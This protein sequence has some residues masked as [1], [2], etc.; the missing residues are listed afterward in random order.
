MSSASGKHID[1]SSSAKRV[2]TLQLP[3]LCIRGGYFYCDNEALYLRS[4]RNKCSL[5]QGF[6]QA[7]DNCLSLTEIIKTIYGVMDNPSVRMRESLH[8]NVH[9]ILSDLRALL[10]DRY[11]HLKHVEWLPYSRSDNA[12]YLYRFSAEYVLDQMF[13]PAHVPDGTS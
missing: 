3:S 6:L 4:A 13:P 7:P 12:W 1:M 11:S 9:R 2:A 5:I 8:K 10:H